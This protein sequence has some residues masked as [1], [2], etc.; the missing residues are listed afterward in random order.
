MASLM[1]EMPSR[2]ATCDTHGEYESVNF[3]GTRWSGC[4]KCA[5]AQREAEEARGRDQL[6]RERRD[7]LLR[8]CGIEGRFSEASFENFDAAS[9]KQQKV[10]DACR[11]FAET[12][13]RDSGIGLWLIGPPG[14]GK[15]HLGS[16]MV[17]HVIEQRDAEAA[18][19][20]GREII[21]ML[22]A[23]WGQKGARDWDGAAT[24]EEQLISDLGHMPLL[25][26]DEIG[27]SFGTDAEHVQLF[28]IIDL[29]YKHRRP[30]VL[31]SNLSAKDIKAAIG[32]RAYDR[33]REGAQM[34]VC[35]WVSHRGQA[36]KKPPLEAVK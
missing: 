3:T 24:T 17:R 25:V 5:A 29:R 36:P 27:V 35:D 1:R 19:F 6:R 26:I 33:L 16:A 20:S 15:T 32:E 31:L 28:D 22:R 2:A 9:D 30:T 4:P 8:H 12:V 21:R 23:T 10:L 13:K 7:V 18:I 14:T 11:Q 34:L